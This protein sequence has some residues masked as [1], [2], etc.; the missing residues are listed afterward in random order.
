MSEVLDVKFIEMSNDDIKDKASKFVGMHPVLANIIIIAVIAVIGIWIVYFSIAIFTKHGESDIV[1]SVENIS[2]T[3]AIKVLHDKGF[4]VDIRDSVY[5]DAVKP[6][7]VVEQFPK[8]NS[9]VKPGRKVFLY[10]N[11]VHPKEVV[12][13]EDNNPRE[14]ALKSFSFRQGM[15]RLEELGFKRVRVVR[16]LGD[17]DC[18][19]KILANGKPVKKMQK[20][21]VNA[22]IVVEVYDGRLS[23]MRDSLQNAE[24]IRSFNEENGYYTDENGD[25]VFD[26]SE[27]NANVEENS[28]EEIEYLE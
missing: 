19:V 12:I 23:Q 5:N 28:E 16:V 25:V 15:A 21:P 14:D 11:A 6:G 18:I 2:Y 24:Y 27:S 22:D 17:N 20:V 8:G 7:Y 13:D 10:I 9:V 3:E 26:N 4:R 1:P